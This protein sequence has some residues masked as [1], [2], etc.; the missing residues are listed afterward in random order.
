MMDPRV[1]VTLQL[2]DEHNASIQFGLAEASSLMGLSEAYLLRLFHR[3]VGTS[4][5]RRLREARISRAAQLLRDYSRPIKQIAGECGY[6]DIS[7]FYRDF[8]SVYGATPRE[9]R[10]SNLIAPVNIPA[11]PPTPRR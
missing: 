9:L 6:N 8:R 3:E 5:R 1:R 10:L 4:F 11:N 7:N 2:I